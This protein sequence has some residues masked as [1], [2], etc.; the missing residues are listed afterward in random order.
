MAANDELPRGLTLQDSNTAG[1]SGAT[2][3]FPAVS[4]VSWVLTNIQAEAV[5][6]TNGNYDLLVTTSLGTSGPEGS[7]AFTVSNSEIDTPDYSWEGQVAAPLD[8]ALTVSITSVG[9]CAG[10]LTVTANPI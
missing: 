4:G 9:N 5:S 7:L 8:T 2:V 10:F 1:T 3:T 6:G